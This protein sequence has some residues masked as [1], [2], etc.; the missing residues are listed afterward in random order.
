[1]ETIKLTINMPVEVQRELKSLVAL[2]GTTMTDVLLDCAKDYIRKR[3]QQ[4]DR[5]QEE[6]AEYKTD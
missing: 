3:R 1:M 5:T 6:R 4:P 2:E